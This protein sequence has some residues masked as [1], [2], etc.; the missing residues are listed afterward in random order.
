MF[1]VNYT[2]VQFSCDLVERAS[3]VY[4]YVPQHKLTHAYA[5]LWW[6]GECKAAKTEYM[7]CLSKSLGNNNAC[8]TL[9]KAYLECRM[10]MYVLFSRPCDSLPL[11]FPDHLCLHGLTVRPVSLN[12]W[13]GIMLIITN[14]NL[15]F[16]GSD[17]YAILCHIVLRGLMK[18]EEWRT[19]G[20][21]S[22]LDST[23]TSAVIL[24]W[25]TNHI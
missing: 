10:K 2:A 4:G 25:W 17:G 11:I 14:L 19:L 9:S 7:N 18:K 3:S 15:A 21:V 16:S 12:Q 6:T 23:L 24:L 20:S 13:H 8:R 1:G 22:V 5:S